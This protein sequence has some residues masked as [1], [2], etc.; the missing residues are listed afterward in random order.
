MGGC[1]ITHFIKEVMDDIRDI[2]SGDGG[3][4]CAYT[5]GV[6]ETD[7]HAKKIADELADMKEKIR[8]SSEKKEQKI[9]DYIN[10]SL[11]ELLKVLQNVNRQVYGGRTLNINIK[12]IKEKNETL[13]KQ[14]V[15]CIGNI[16]E[17]RLVLTDKEL[18]VILEERDDKKRKKNFDSFCRRVQG[19]ALSGLKKKIETTIRKQEEMV[20][21]EIKAR[22]TEVDKS[23]KSTEKAYT[24]ILLAKEKSEADVTK[25]QIKYVY[26]YALA[27]ILLDQLQI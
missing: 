7:A 11:E 19:Q 23:M 24:E 26:Q 12:G 25:T 22:L 20:E 5:P 27:D 14:V 3:G 15:G 16:M 1:C 13:K 6:S 4:G 2:F 17:E 8:K 18:S 10:G 21:K 9:I